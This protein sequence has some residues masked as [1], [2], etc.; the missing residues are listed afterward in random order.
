MTALRLFGLPTAYGS[1]APV[2][3]AARALSSHVLAL[4]LRRLPLGGSG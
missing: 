3:L 4:A 1:T 2:A